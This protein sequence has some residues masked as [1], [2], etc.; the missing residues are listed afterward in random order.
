M[1]RWQNTP[2]CLLPFRSALGSPCISVWKVASPQWCRITGRFSFF[3]SQA[4]S[5][6]REGAWTQWHFSKALQDRHGLWWRR[7]ERRYDP[8]IWE[9]FQKVCPLQ[10]L[11][12]MDLETRTGH[13]SLDSQVMIQ[14]TV[15][16]PRHPQTGPMEW[17]PTQ[18]SNTR[19]WNVV[20][21]GDPLQHS[22][23]LPAQC[24]G[25][26]V[27]NHTL[28]SRRAAQHVNPCSFQPYLCKSVSTCQITTENHV[29]ECTLGLYIA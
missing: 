18:G 29:W 13:H 21:W 19:V 12:P 26:W 5:W 27:R 14:S 23:S 22:W 1:R 11:Q 8:L 20:Y 7:E 16:P 3:V 24:A 9:A 2:L 10:S 17:T 25:V 4:W 28:D 15:K 6:R